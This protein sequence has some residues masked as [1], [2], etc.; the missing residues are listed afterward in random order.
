V[1]G[2]SA[3]WPDVRGFDRSE[4]QALQIAPWGTN[5]LAFSAYSTYQYGMRVAVAT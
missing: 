3:G 4:G 5:P 2:R 1:T